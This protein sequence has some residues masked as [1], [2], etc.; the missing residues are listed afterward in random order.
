MHRLAYLKRKKKKSKSYYS[1]VGESPRYWR[2]IRSYQTTFIQHEAGAN[3][4][5]A[6]STFY[7]M[8]NVHSLNK[9]EDNK[10]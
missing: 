3:T 6:I 5:K 9:C 7:K 10:K 2:D 8:L 1:C 4:Y